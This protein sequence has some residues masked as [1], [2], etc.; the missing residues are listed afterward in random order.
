[1]PCRLGCSL[2]VSALDRM[3]CAFDVTA[4]DGASPCGIADIALRELIDFIAS[5][6]TSARRSELSCRRSSA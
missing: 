4:E 2:T 6:A 3:A 5:K 1:M